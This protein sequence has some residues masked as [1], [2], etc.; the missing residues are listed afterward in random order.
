M[1]PQLCK[2]EDVIVVGG[3][4]SGG[5]ADMFLSLVAKH[6]YLLVLASGLADSMSQYLIRRI[7][8]CRDITLLCRTE[9]VGMDGAGNLESVTW[10]NRDTGDT[11]THPIRHIFSMTGA[12]PNT[13]W[14]EGC[15]ALDSSGFIKTGADLAADDLDR[16]G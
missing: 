6:V 13:A 1:E 16:A 9:I 5:Q 10:R 12:N 11:E 14:L 4:N 2:G 7:E 3:G 15:V 8:E